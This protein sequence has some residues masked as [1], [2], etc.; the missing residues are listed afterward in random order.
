M[1]RASSI[2]FEAYSDKARNGEDFAHSGEKSGQSQHFS[3]KYRAIGKG[4]FEGGARHTAIDSRKVAKKDQTRETSILPINLETFL[5][6]AQR[7]SDISL[8]SE[9]SVM[10]FFRITKSGGGGGSVSH[11]WGSLKW[12]E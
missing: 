6:W 8:S 11:F 10:T 5:L 4:S 3:R 1:H 2:N 9:I 12:N 7:K